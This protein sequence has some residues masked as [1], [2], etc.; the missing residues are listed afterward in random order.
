MTPMDEDRM[1]ELEEDALEMLRM[2]YLDQLESDSVSARRDA[3]HRIRK[4]QWTA[5]IPHLLRLLEDDAPYVFD[6]RGELHIA[7]VRADV[8]ETL[9]ELYRVRGV[10]PECGPVKVSAPMPTRTAIAQADKELARLS[11]AERAAVSARVHDFMQQRYSY[12]PEQEDALRAYRALQE[13]GRISY[14]LETIDPVIYLTPLQ[15]E[16]I[17]GQTR[18]PRPKPHLRI[19]RSGA[20]AETLGWLY[21]DPATRK[22]IVDFSD[23]RDAQDIAEW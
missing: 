18:S 6:V 3:L 9:E 8:V 5:G 22:W 13:I 21:R 20:P 23:A 4:D 15:Q 12:S 17:A 11:P 19:S 14:R 2:Q 7:E 16:I 1:R 10:A